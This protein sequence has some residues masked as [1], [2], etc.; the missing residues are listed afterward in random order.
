MKKKR[1][2]QRIKFKLFDLKWYLK[3]KRAQVV[4]FLTRNTF[5]YH[6]LKMTIYTDISGNKKIFIFDKNMAI[7]YEWHSSYVNNQTGQTD[8]GEHYEVIKLE[9]PQ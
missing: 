1:I 2:I 8:N 9:R 4:A 3:I 5:Y 6:R 7:D